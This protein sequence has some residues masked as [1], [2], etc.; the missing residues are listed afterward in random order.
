MASFQPPVHP[1]LGAKLLRTYVLRLRHFQITGNTVV[2]LF[3]I[4]PDKLMEGRI[5]VVDSH[6]APTVSV[7]THLGPRGKPVHFLFFRH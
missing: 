7:L 4:S 1:P 5:A 2:G 6:W 3:E